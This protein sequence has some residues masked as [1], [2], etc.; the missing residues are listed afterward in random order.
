MDQTTILGLSAFLLEKLNITSAELLSALNE[1][2]GV[3]VNPY[4]RLKYDYFGKDHVFPTIDD[5]EVPEA[6]CLHTC[7]NSLSSTYQLQ[8]Q[9]LSAHSQHL[10]NFECHSHLG[11]AFA[12][13]SSTKE[14][15]PIFV[16]DK[17]KVKSYIEF[18]EV[19][20]SIPINSVNSSNYIEI[21]QK[22]LTQ[23]NKIF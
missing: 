11:N 14:G 8:Q 22:L 21:A 12:T 2:S 13:L 1:L 4:E 19:A 15:E 6:F 17:E 7:I 18:H 5:I 16:V 3:P 23:Y 10:E 9:T 20:S